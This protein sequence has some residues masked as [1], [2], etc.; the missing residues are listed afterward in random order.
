MLI[1]LKNVIKWA[2]IFMKNKLITKYF[3]IYIYICLNTENDKTYLSMLPE[4]CRPIV[5]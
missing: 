1:L 3:Y 4:V 2:I 5:L